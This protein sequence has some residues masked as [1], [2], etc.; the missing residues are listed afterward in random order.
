MSDKLTRIDATSIGDHTKLLPSDECYF[1]LEYTSGKP[2]SFG[3][4]NSLI[5][6]LKKKPSTSNQY[7]LGYK[8]GAINQCSA[9]FRGAI[10]ADWIASATLVAIPGSKISGH[11]DFDPRMARV[12]NGIGA[13]ASQRL[14]DL[15]RFRQ[16]FA[17]SH[18]CQ[19]GERPTVEQL[20]AN[21]E[22]VEAV[23]T[24]PP[25][26]IG[27]FDDVLTAGVHYRAVHNVLSARFPGVPIVGFFVAR[28]VFAHEELEALDL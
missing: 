19:P 2:F 12:I 4:G 1:W 26:R 10:N 6:N 17:A 27:V 5:S 25:A 11:P 16:S 22:I 28:R 20:V 15:I 14:R 8:Q 7:E 18:E 13:D 24:P 9:F 21:L 3:R 23:A